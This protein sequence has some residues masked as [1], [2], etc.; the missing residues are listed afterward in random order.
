MSIKQVASCISERR[1][2]IVPT[3]QLQRIAY[4]DGSVSVT[5]ADENS[6]K[7]RLSIVYTD[8]DSYPASG[9]LLLCEDSTYEGKIAALAERFQ[10]RAPLSSVLSKVSMAHGAKGP[11]HRRNSS[12]GLLLQVFDV[13]GIPYEEEVLRSTESG[14]AAAASGDAG[15]SD[16][17][18][19]DESQEEDFDSDPELS[20]GD[21]RELLLHCGFRTNKWERHEQ[22]LEAAEATN[23]MALSRE[24]GM[25]S[26][27]Q[28]FNTKEAFMRL[29]NELLEIMKW[30]D[31]QLY[32]DSVGDDI[33][34]WDIWIAGFRQDSAVA[35]VW[36]GAKQIGAGT[37]RTGRMYDSS[38]S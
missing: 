20:D 22:D 38:L 29:S 16:A 4:E 30:Q 33:Y 35:K 27:R 15:G 26:K 3:S 24:Q 9:A 37:T 34:Q 25:A 36:P 23:S 14:K 28:I 7:V 12:D 31:P 1:D 18:E 21:D 19:E 2:E 8:A 5:L 11:P 32:G 10:E 13:I 6:A 17:M